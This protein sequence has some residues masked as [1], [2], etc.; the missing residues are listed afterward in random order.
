MTMFHCL[1]CVYPVDIQILALEVAPSPDVHLFGYDAVNWGAARYIREAA[2][3]FRRLLP[4]VPPIQR[5]PRGDCAGSRCA[6][7]HV[8][9]HTAVKPLLSHP[10]TEQFT[11]SPQIC[12]GPLLRRVVRPTSLSGTRTA[13]LRLCRTER[14]AC[15][16]RRAASEVE[17][18]GSLL[19]EEEL[20]CN[21][22]AMAVANSA[23]CAR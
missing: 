2:F 14:Y 10:T 20:V 18:N 21:T 9:L 5:N 3:V 6:Q 11:F 23:E 7:P 8:G 17:L 1:Q 22:A 16:T 15:V 12:Y 4:T 19:P 13:P